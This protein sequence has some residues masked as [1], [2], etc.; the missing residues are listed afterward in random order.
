MYG[1]GSFQTADFVLSPR[2]DEFVHEPLKSK[3]STP[4]SLMVLLNLS[5]IGF[6]SQ[7]FQELFALV[8]IPRVEVPNVGHKLLT[9]QGETPYFEIPPSCGSPYHT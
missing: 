5:L 1:L 4:Y 6:Q 2:V 7:T 8:Q 3:I 9:P